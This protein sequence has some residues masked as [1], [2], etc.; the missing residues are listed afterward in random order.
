MHRRP[1]LV[2]QFGL[3][4]HTICHARILLQGSI[5]Y[6]WLVAHHWDEANNNTRPVCLKL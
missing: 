6:D 3:C 2:E 1:Y 5:G 4:V